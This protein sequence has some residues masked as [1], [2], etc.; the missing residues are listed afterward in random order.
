MLNKRIVITGGGSG[1]HV[2]VATGFIDALNEKYTNVSENLLYITSDLGMV[3]EKN[4]TTIEQ[5][6]MEGRDV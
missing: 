6:R 2:S 1:G 4:A 3:G 5:R